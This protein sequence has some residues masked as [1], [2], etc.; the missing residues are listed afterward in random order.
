MGRPRV[1]TIE[2]LHRSCKESGYTLITKKNPS[3]GVKYVDRFK[4]ICNSCLLVKEVN[5]FTIIRGFPCTCKRTYTKEYRDK[6]SRKF[7]TRTMADIRKIVYK[8]NP[9]IMILTKKY[10]NAHQDLTLK[11]RVCGYTWISCFNGGCL[12]CR[13]CADR[14][15]AEA[16]RTPKNIIKKELLSLCRKINSTL[17][18]FDETYVN[19]HSII[20]VQCNI[21]N[22]IRETGLFVLRKL[23]RCRCQVF[24][25]RSE[26]DV[27]NYIRKNYP[28]LTIRE[29][30]RTVVY[31]H[32]TNRYLE[33][34][35]YIPELKLAIEF[36]GDYWHKF[37]SVK[38][39]DNIKR[40]QCAELGIK[41]LQ[42]K[43]TDYN[44]NW[45]GVSS[46]LRANIVYLSGINNINPKIKTGA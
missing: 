42:I 1:H 35:I 11:C 6:M 15:N 46:K 16:Q 30:D 4:R 36:N 33:I 45:R 13:K 14:K 44:N 2:D 39:K 34:D 9:D 37:K 43:E 22:E 3:T 26:K 29:N 20:Y 24:N 5:V 28:A 23:C 21:C 8:R 12:G 40:E 19:T 27:L 25:S 41:L 10:I 17:L 32:N 38:L 18:D 7:R 31:N